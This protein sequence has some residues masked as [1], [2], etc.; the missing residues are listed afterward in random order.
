MIYDC[1]GKL[2]SH[3]LISFITYAENGISVVQAME[4]L[5]ITLSSKTDDFEP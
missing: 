5:T 3:R 4:R 1:L 2:A